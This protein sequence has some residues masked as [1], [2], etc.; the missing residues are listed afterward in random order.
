MTAIFQTRH[1]NAFS[2]KK[3]YT[4]RLRF[5][6]SNSQCSSIGLHDGLAQPTSYKP[7]NFDDNIIGQNRINIA[8]IWL[9]ARS[10]KD[11][12]YL[13]GEAFVE[14]GVL[15]ALP[16]VLCFA[17]ASYIARFTVGYLTFAYMYT[18]QQQMIDCVTREY[19]PGL[20]V[21]A[22]YQYEQPGLA[23]AL[24]LRF[25]YTNQSKYTWDIS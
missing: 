7:V 19:D 1:S 14:F 22:W 6:R 12:W 17:T 23:N 18:R 24:E 8:F 2:W 9:S 5:Q 11:K 15:I 3:T 10:D 25:P 13:L 4:L 16:Y 20:T 21:I